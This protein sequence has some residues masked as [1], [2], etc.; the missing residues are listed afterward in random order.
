MALISYLRL[1]LFSVRIE[2][3]Q[4]LWVHHVEKVSAL[5]SPAPSNIKLDYMLWKK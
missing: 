3:E 4:D 2:R 5:I 1:E